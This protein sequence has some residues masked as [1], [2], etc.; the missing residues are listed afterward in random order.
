MNSDEE[1]NQLREKI[2]STISEAGGM[3]NLLTNLA[4][5]ANYKL[6]LNESSVT[7]N[8]LDNA[9][10]KLMMIDYLKNNFNK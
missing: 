4:N 8:S 9:I 2:Q 1:I 6:E 3:S 10:L 5:Q 7:L